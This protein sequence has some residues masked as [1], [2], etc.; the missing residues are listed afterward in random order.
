MQ[1]SQV[2]RGVRDGEVHLGGQCLNM[3]RRLGEEIDEL[4]SPFAG[5]GPADARE[6]RVEA[7]LERAVGHAGTVAQNPRIIN[8][9]IARLT[10]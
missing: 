6:L 10:S 8:T 5:E 7:L 2:L 4:E 9:S 3:P 1:R